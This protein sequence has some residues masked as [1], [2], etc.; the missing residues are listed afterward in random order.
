[1]AGARC[2]VAPNN[3]TP[4]A[5][6][7]AT[8]PDGNMRLPFSEQRFGVRRICLQHVVT[9]HD[10]FPGLLQLQAARRSVEQARHSHRLQL[11]GSFCAAAGQ[12]LG[13]SFLIWEGHLRQ[14]GKRLGVLSNRRLMITLQRH[15]PCSPM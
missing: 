11:F 8:H 10:S 15:L 9:V 5:S 2:R 3:T 7:S 4:V 1:M 12:V 13:H 6:T 14:I